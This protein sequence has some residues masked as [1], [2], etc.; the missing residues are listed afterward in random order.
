MPWRHEAATN[1]VGDEPHAG[2]GVRQ[3]AG[4]RAA[5]GTR[6]QLLRRDAFQSCTKGLPN[7]H[8]YASPVVHR[9]LPGQLALLPHALHRE[10]YEHG[11]RQKDGRQKQRDEAPLRA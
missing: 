10:Q 8:E 3:I 9:A 5:R 11:T 7:L 1:N 4:D 6:A 2:I